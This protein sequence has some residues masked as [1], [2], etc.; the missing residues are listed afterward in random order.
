MTTIN[1]PR[2]DTQIRQALALEAIA[3]KMGAE[4]KDWNHIASIVKGG[5]GIAA[6][7]VGSKLTTDNGNGAIIEWDVVDHAEV[8]GRPAMYLMTHGCVDNS[9]QYD[10]PE[11]LYYAPE[12]LAPGKYYFTLLNG[13]D[14]DYGGGQSYTFTLTKAVSAGGVLTFPWAWQQ[15]AVNTKLSS[16]ADVKDTTALETVSVAIGTTG[17]F[18][19]VADGTNENMN[20]THRIRYGSNNWKESALRQWL[21][22]KGT[23]GSVWVPKTKFDRPPNWST[24]RAGFMQMLPQD[25]IDV[26]R[27][28]PI[29]TIT[30]NVFEIEDTLN[31]SYTTTDKFW[32]ASRYQ[33]FGT[34]EGSNLDEKQ[35]EYF[36]GATDLDR[37]KYNT[38]DV[39]RHWWLRSPHP[40]GA[41]GVRNVNS[42]GVLSGHS[43]DNAN[44]AVPA[45]VVY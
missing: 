27:S 42:T 33:I 2:E 28:V 22:S 15:P 30:N 29:K 9:I 21:N 25:F 19:G 7:P 31:S 35:F 34:T 26:V 4:V 32:L 6:F 12:G 41:N 39:S 24:S 1:I 14:P 23:A 18:L 5:G 16:Y 38:S 36:V 10:A 8:N 20:H 37:I 40:G 3:S 45:C 13:Y 17:T 44:A 43:A 11:A